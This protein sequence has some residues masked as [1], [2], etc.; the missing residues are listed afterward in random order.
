MLRD[1]LLQAVKHTSIYSI[2]WIANGIAGVCLLPVY[3]RYLSRAE[4]GALDLVGQNNVI[5]KIVFAAC[6]T[7]S[8]GRLY[9]DASNEEEK[10]KIISSG[11]TSAI[12]AGILAGACLL[13][14]NSQISQ[15]LLGD[16]KY[17]SLIIAGAFVLTMDIAFTGLTYEFLVT[18]KSA[19]YVAVNL[20]RLVTA[21]TGNLVCLVWFELGAISMLIGNSLGILLAN[22]C[23]AVPHFR[24][25]GFLIDVPTL[26]RMIAFGAPMIVAGILA[27]LL[28]SSDRL[29]LRP[30]QDLEQVGLFMMGLQFPNMLNAILVS[31]FG[32]IWSGSLM[33]TM[34]K[35]PDADIQ[36]GRF[37]TYLLALFI[38]AQTILGIFSA[39]LLEI[40]AAPKFAASIPVAPIACLGFSFHAF[41]LF[42]VSKAFTHNNPKR[43]IICYAAPLLAKIA[44]TI[45]LVP[46]YGFMGSACILTSGYLLFTVTCYLAFKKMNT[47]IFEWPRIISLFV[48]SASFLLASYSTNQSD[49]VVQILLQFLLAG[50]YILCLALGPIFSKS[51]KL[52]LLH[53]LINRFQQFRNQPAIKENTDAGN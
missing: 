39:S 15:L 45:F 48:L 30:F 51:E 7:Y 31:S 38:A 16:V 14:L 8:L 12:A 36:I 50:L 52:A 11:A 26:K 46:I 41:Y 1:N 9:H 25:Y 32:A 4:Y 40:L 49:L 13:L 28:H 42:L 23:M 44:L 43:M 18:K 53:E 21:I 2:S 34:A 27:T 22:T 47:T 6:F 24:K 10:N 3:S 20:A 5:F 37:A 33:F 35:Q 29:M 19:R 17:S